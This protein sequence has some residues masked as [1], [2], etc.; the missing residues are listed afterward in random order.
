M[1][2]QMDV[3]LLANA[4]FYRALSLADATAMRNIWLKSEEASCVHPGWNKVLGYENIQHTWAAIFV[5][6]GPVHIWSSEETVSFEDDLAWVAC[7]ENVD[8]SATTSGAIITV[9]ARNA[10]YHLRSGWRLLHHE[11]EPIPE[12]DF[13]PAN[14]R[15]ALN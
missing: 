8:A 9:R 12:Q 11:A 14:Q 7:I 3:I 4:Q 15:L 13:L 10:F 5:N 6:Q 1:T 2:E